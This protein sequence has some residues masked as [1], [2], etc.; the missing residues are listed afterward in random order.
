[1]SIATDSGTIWTE[2][3]NGLTYQQS[4]GFSTNWPEFERFKTR[5]QWPCSTPATKNFPRPVIDFI[6]YVTR[7]K[8]AAV[9]SQ[10]IKMLFTAEEVPEGD[11]E[12]AN[13]IVKG[14]SDFTDYSQIVWNDVRQKDLN[15]RAVDDAV[16]NG[17]G[18]FHYYWDNYD[19]GGTVTKY[20]GKLKGEVIDAI[21]FF[22]A[23]PQQDDVQKQPYIEISSREDTDKLVQMAKSNKQPTDLIQSDKNTSEEG[24][25]AAQ[26]EL[27]GSNKTTCV[28]KYYRQ[29]IDPKN[30]YTG[31]E[32]YWTKV[33]ESAV[34]V[35]PTPLTPKDATSK[36][37]LYPVEVFNWERR[38]KC[39]YGIGEIEGLIS[40]QKALN[41][42]YGMMLLAVQ[43]TAWPKMLVKQGALQE[44][45]TNTPGEVLTDYS[46]NGD[47][48]KYMQ[49]PAFSTTPASILDN[50][51]GMERTMT[52]TTEIMTGE[53]LGANMAASA[54]IALQN[55][56]RQPTHNVQDRFYR[57]IE[58]IGRIWEQFYK[59]YFN[60]PRSYTKSDP[61]TG[62]KIPQTFLGSQYADVSFAME[63]D[64]GPGSEYSESVQMSMMETLFNKGAISPYQFVKYAPKNIFPQGLVQDMQQAATQQATQPPQIPAQAQTGLNPQPM[65]AVQ[66]QAQGQPQAQQ[67]TPQMLQQLLMMIQQ[68]QG[69]Q[70]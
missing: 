30:P 22:V 8:K 24:Y 41:T 53:T 52:G 11:P 67:I 31:S 69:G 68:K 63:I 56:A 57:S 55:Q 50:M 25:D 3:K 44:Q 62:A 40:F 32:V 45:P 4:M 51:L 70:Q 48:I 13:T 19:H 64:V 18:I 60:Q 21:N 5:Q 26:I 39:I 36:I 47:G 46:G 17:P 38:K 12:T 7:N 2:R 27:D 14:A 16:T 15:D 43:Q 9:L 59:A 10:S 66:P 61:A 34:I 65:Q 49:P 20:I 54:I 58:R 33:T 28:T 23:N 29:P 37:T 35:P 42:G 6:S 1:M